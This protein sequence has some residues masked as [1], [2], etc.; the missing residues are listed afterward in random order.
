VVF[1]IVT[2]GGRARGVAVAAEVAGNTI[3]EFVE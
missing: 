1:G 2:H 3:I